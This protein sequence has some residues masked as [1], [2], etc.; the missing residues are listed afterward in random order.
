MIRGDTILIFQ[1]PEL[2]FFPH[3]KGIVFSPFGVPERSFRY[4]VYKVLYI[5]KLP[6][7]SIFWGEW[8]KHL[9]EAEQVIIFDYGYQAGMEN[10][11]KKVNPSCKV[12]L[13]FWN[14]INE[15]QKNHKLFTDKNAIYSTDKGCCEAYHLKYNHIFYT[16]DYYKPYSGMFQN[17][18]FF[19]G[20]D[21]G[22]A[23]YIHALKGILE[24]SGLVCDIRVVTKS[25]DS[26]YRR[27]YSDILINMPLQY[28]EYCEEL[29][30]NGILLDINQKGQTALT[31]RVLESIY[32]SKKL[33]TNNQDIVHYDFYHENNI[34][35]LPRNLSELSPEAIRAFLNQPF[36]P[37]SE[38]I[39]ENYDFEHWK[40][41]FSGAAGK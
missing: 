5:L 36:L 17:H 15:K 32:F 24:R 38:N 23:Q 41:Q 7:C 11:I 13:Y 18:L 31:M 40:K 20:M 39:L 34:F 22:R 9:K 27:K 2:Y 10:Y 19:L 21:K 26:G 12:Y 37:Y 35:I 6:C 3:L 28:S 30:R 16:R 1:K 4:L 33:I 8:K 29:E 14:I 25:K